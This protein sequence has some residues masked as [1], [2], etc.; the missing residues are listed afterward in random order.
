MHDKNK[1]KLIGHKRNCLGSMLIAFSF[2]HRQQYRWSDVYWRSGTDLDTLKP[3]MLRMLVP[4]FLSSREEPDHG[5][6]C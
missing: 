5:Q 2:L 1:A 4:A 3:V 6:P